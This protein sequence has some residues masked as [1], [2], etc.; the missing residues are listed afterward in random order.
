MSISRSRSRR[1]S[2]QFKA[3]FAPAF[4][5]RVWIRSCVLMAALP[6]GC[7]PMIDQN[8][9]STGGHGAAVGPAGQ[10]TG[11]GGTSGSIGS[12]GAPT[13]TGGGSDGGLTPGTG[14]RSGIG[15][16]VVATG[17]APGSPGSG[18]GTTGRGGGAGSGAGG[19]TISGSGGSGTQP[20]LTCTPGAFL[21]EAFESYMVGAAPTGI[22][23]AT[24]RGGGTIT[25]DTMRVF[26]GTK[27][28]HVTGL[29]NGDVAHI[30]T[31][32]A[33]SANTVFVR[34]MMYTVGYPS[35]S[36]V[37]SRLAR[38]GTTADSGPDSAY[39]LSSY[40]GTA[41]E[42]VDSIYLRSVSTHLNDTNLLNR[43]VCWE[44]EIDK[45]GGVGKVFPHIWL[46]GTALA[47]AA[48]GS[49][50]HAGT[51]TSWDPIPFEKFTLGLEGNQPDAVK[52]DFWLDDVAVA[53][54]RIGCAKP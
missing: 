48:A 36:G 28:L 50:S 30:T 44:F 10:M 24:V 22:W 2:G 7:S 21:C 40:N 11:N 3:K 41:I 25:V 45:T 39:S 23:S 47:L 18:G 54:Q 20:G 12:G 9:G 8:V 6:A 53:S 16:A 35:S 17:G 27:S 32:L 1:M 49:S 52:G 14:G 13:T 46:D 37:H 33:I 29:I 38:L 15:G 51:S 4:D 19:T 5:R 31:P 43:W 34:F 26:T 42:K